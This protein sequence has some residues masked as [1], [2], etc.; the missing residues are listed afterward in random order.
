MGWNPFKSSWH[1]APRSTFSN[2]LGSVGN[3]YKGV[4]G[5]DSGGLLSTDRVG[6]VQG[7]D[8]KQDKADA[9]AAG[10]AAAAAAVKQALFEAS[11]RA[12][13]ERLALKRRRGFGASMIVNP[14]LGSG[15]VLGG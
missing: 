4:F 6:Q 1:L 11:T 9:A 7:G 3:F 8:P 2:A 15:S 14:T 12:G 13:L 5:M 10:D